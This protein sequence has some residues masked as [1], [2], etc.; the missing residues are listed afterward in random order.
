MRKRIAIVGQEEDVSQAIQTAAQAKDALL[1]FVGAG[2]AIPPGTAA[3][4]CTTGALEAGLEAVLA[5]AAEQE[6]LLRL[7]ADAIACREGIPLGASEWVREHATR[8][9][10]AL[11]LAPDDQLTLERAALLRDV[12]KLRIPNDILLKKDVLDYDEWTLL[13]AHSKLGA[14]LLEGRNVCTDV[15]DVIRHHHE[16]W[17]GDG[18]PD[19]LEKE[20]IPLLARAMRIIDVYCAMTSA[21]HY[22]S[23]QA[24]HEEAIEHL[25]S[26]RGKHFDPGL[27][28]TFVNAEVGQTEQT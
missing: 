27:I 28:D 10:L 24:T 17:D 12:G 15:L 3:V 1:K 4:L 18:Y 11:G 25:R 26:E 9:A 7:I 5:A 22:R 16:C 2:K 13:Q 19:H 14:E 21:R 8:F 20:S 23:G 6:A